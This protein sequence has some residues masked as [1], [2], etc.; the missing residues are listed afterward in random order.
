MLVIGL[1]V[2]TQGARA[3]AVDA[4]GKVAAEASEPLRNVEIPGLPP[5]WA[6]Q[7]P[8]CWWEAAVLCL[9]RVVDRVGANRIRAIACDS[10]SG[11][12]VPVDV[13]GDCLRPA[14]MYNDNRA[15]AE[16]GEV[17]AAAEELIARLGYRFPPAFAL[18]KMLWLK[19]HEPETFARTHCFLHATDFLAFRLTGRMVSESSSALKS[20]VDLIGLVWPDFLETKLGIPLS[21]LPFILSPGDPIGP[22]SPEASM[23]TGL[24]PGTLVVAGATDGTASFLASGAAGAGDWN[25]TLGTTLVV[26]GVSQELI[27][28]PQG[29]LY[30]HRHP[31]GWWLPGGASNVG[32]EYLSV[33]FARE[34][35]KA[36]DARALPLTPTDLLVYPL[37][38]TGERLPFVSATA[39][40]F[41]EGTPASRDALYA[42]CLEGVAL[43]ERWIYDL[44][45]ELGAGAGETLYAT[46]GGS[47]SREWLQ[48]RANVLQK[49]LLLPRIAEAAMG[50]CILAASR[51]LYGS[52]TEAVRQMVSIADRIEPDARLSAAYDEQYWR[53]RE[54][55]ARRGFV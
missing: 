12:F 34:D 11:T 3:L 10:T 23:E 16:A 32:G 28:D 13:K 33:H 27:R 39:R 31:E 7:T 48:I 18:P 4:T 9:R 55:C 25:S 26:R 5:G 1:D 29:R 6:E 20:G 2:G 40:G 41:V 24:S 43:V 37:A 30:C 17:N 47:K 22:V 51:T 36:L 15:V 49:E 53:F 52:L 35:L 54:A 46:G 38:R 14:L 21:G 8:E 45:E 50:A 44:A 42:G 19:R